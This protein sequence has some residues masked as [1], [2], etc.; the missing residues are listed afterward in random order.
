MAPGA[1]GLLISA[2]I[3]LQAAMCLAAGA[4]AWGMAAAF[5]ILLAWP[6]NR[7]LARAVPAS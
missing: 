7:W 6:L 3:P 4:G 2:L 5:L 1:I